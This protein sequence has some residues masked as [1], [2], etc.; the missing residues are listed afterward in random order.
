VQ[1]PHAARAAARVVSA[2]PWMLDVHVAASACRGWLQHSASRWRVLSAAAQCVDGLT[3]QPSAAALM[4]VVCSHVVCSQPSQHQIVSSAALALSAKTGIILRTEM[5]SEAASSHIHIPSFAE[6]GLVAC[7]AMATG[8]R[9][10]ATPMRVTRHRRACSI[11]CQQRQ[12]L[13]TH[14]TPI[15]CHEVISGHLPAHRTW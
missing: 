3:M 2:Q 15:T 6:E 12:L 13:R 14:V 4:H 5:S 11:A 7:C 8:L 1:G 9:S 10:L